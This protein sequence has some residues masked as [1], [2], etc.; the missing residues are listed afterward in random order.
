MGVTPSGMLR[1][2]Q[3]K[4]T[5]QQIAHLPQYIYFFM[6]FISICLVLGDKLWPRNNKKWILLKNSL[7]SLL[8]VTSAAHQWSDLTPICCLWM[9]YCS[10][11]NS[12]PSPQGPPANFL[13]IFR[14]CASQNLSLRF[15]ICSSELMKMNVFNMKTSLDHGP[16]C[17]GSNSSE[18]LF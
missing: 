11:I 2:G 4:E 14:G 16:V 13:H 10:L 12:P 5:S 3:H 9:L 7:A 8:Y 17:H 18:G 15:P 6:D 1:L